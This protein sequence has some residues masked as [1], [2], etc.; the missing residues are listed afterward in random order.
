ME[1]PRGRLLVFAKA[2]VPG[3]VKTRLIPA[4]GATKSA[5]LHTRLCIATLD[6]AAGLAPVDLWGSPD[7]KHAFFSACRATYGVDLRVQRGADLGARMANAM[8]VALATARYAV[9]IGTDCPQLTRDDLKE[10]F[11]T[12][13]EGCDAVLGPAMDGGYVLIGLARPAPRVFKDI[14]WGSDRVLAQTRAR[15]AEATLTWRELPP[16][17]DV[18]RPEDLAEPVSQ[19]L[20]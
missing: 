20:R 1:Y 15:L 17:R 7:T 10:A 19:Y 14:D 5:E 16:R 12:L 13:D 3:Q 8:N 6:K 4:L 9:L 11:Q 2:P 18:D